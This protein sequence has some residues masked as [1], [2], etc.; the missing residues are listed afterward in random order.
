MIID[1]AQYRRI[2]ADPGTGPLV[3]VSPQIKI[4]TGIVDYKNLVG[5]QYV[6]EYYLDSVLL[7]YVEYDGREMKR[8]I[9]YNARGDIYLEKRYDSDGNVKYVND[10]VQRK[11]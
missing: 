2:K 7:G 5:E 11:R 3:M 6:R 8:E 9:Y 10:K 4:K 1:G